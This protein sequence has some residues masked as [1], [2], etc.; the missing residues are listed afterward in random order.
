MKDLLQTSFMSAMANKPANEWVQVKQ[1]VHKK[2]VE[3]TKL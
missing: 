3:Y 2:G 1:S